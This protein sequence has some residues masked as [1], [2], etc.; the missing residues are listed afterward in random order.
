MT[1][2][3][4]SP[5][6][7]LGS[8]EQKNTNEKL[9]KEEEEKK[10]YISLHVYFR[11]PFVFFSSSFTFSSENGILWTHLPLSERIVMNFFIACSQLFLL[12][13]YIDVQFPLLD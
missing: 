12:I 13:V 11:L 2:P 10:R 6:L 3:R 5:N 8:L 1:P 9:R 4:K 7:G